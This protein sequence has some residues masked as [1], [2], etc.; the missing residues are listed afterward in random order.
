MRF[1][2]FP[3][4]LQIKC[5]FSSSRLRVRVKKKTITFK[6]AIFDPRDLLSGIV[7]TLFYLVKES[8]LGANFVAVDSL[9]SLMHEILFLVTK[10]F[11]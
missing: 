3:S 6:A 11:D 4:D 2:L 7:W 9:I 10:L 8:R 1:N 5:C